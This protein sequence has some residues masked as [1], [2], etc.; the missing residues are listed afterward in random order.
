M[1]GKGENSTYIYFFIPI[2]SAPD[3]RNTDLNADNSDGNGDHG[4]DGENKV[5]FLLPLPP[6]P[7]QPPF[8]F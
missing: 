3:F 6:N 4:D 2:C 7:F 8:L 1:D 5:D